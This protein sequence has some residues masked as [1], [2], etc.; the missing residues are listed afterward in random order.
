MHNDVGYRI[1][2]ENMT[3]NNSIKTITVILLFTDMIFVLIIGTVL[4][5]DTI[6]GNQIDINIQKNKERYYAFPGCTNMS[7][8]NW[9]VAYGNG[10]EHGSGDMFVEGRI[11]TDCGQTWGSPFMIRDHVY[12]KTSDVEMITAPNGSVICTYRQGNND[13]CGWSISYDNGTTWKYKGLI[14]GGTSKIYHVTGLHIINNTIYACAY[15]HATGQNCSLWTSTDNGSSWQFYSW[16]NSNDANDEWDFFPINDTYWI[17]FFRHWS[18]PADPG[19]AWWMESHDKGLT[20]TNLT[21]RADEMGGEIHSPQF[22]WLNQEHNII[23]L[24]GRRYNTTANTVSTRYWISD[25]NGITWQNA[26]DIVLGT[27]GVDDTGYTGV[28]EHSNKAFL[29]YYWGKYS[30]SPKP[31]IYGIW[32]YDSMSYFVSQSENESNLPSLITP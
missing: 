2:I 25:N 15:Q 14:D 30:T 18:D 3:K 21:D 20:W 1:G 27:Y 22:N 26:T 23:L 29:V 31:N 28:I 19:H 8:G 7:N 17:A 5:Y 11:S 32:I 13:S 9:I 24:S 10:T 4:I 12:G 6:H 16:V